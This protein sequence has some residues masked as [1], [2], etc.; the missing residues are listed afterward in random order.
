MVVRRFLI[1]FTALA[2]AGA[3]FY[4]TGCSGSRDRL[5]VIRDAGSRRVYGKWPLKEAKEFAIEFVHSVNQSPV[6]ETFRA[7][8][9]KIKPV[10]VR[11]ASFGAGMLSDLEEDQIMIQD[12]EAL[13]IKGFSASFKSLNYIVGTVSDH[14]L[15][16]NDECISLRELCGRNAQITICI[17]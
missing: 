11:F 16:I 3:V 13:I 8:N 5:L 10:S 1:L 6:R 12:G 9:G 17:K 4:T 2:M 15:F 7:D 14:L